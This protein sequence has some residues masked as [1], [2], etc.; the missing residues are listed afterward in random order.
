[1]RSQGTE[2]PGD[3]AAPDHVPWDAVHAQNWNGMF[4]QAGLHLP[5]NRSLFGNMDTPIQDYRLA[6]MR[7]NPE[8]DHSY[9]ALHPAQ[10]A[11]PSRAT[12]AHC[13]SD[14]AKRQQWW[15]AGIRHISETSRDQP[16]S[17]RNTGEPGS[18]IP[19]L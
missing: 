7:V 2:T 10:G 13:L 8:F 19:M 1:M 11:G 12:K 15:I 4:R 18:T 9:P 14:R 16:P 5:M 17:P 6:L 3:N